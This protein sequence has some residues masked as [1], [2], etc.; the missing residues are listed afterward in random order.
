MNSASL[1]PS[2]TPPSAFI[3]GSQTNNYN[4]NDQGYQDQSNQNVTIEM[5]NKKEYADDGTEREVLTTRIKNVLFN[6][7]D[8]QSHQIISEKD[9]SSQQQIKRAVFFLRTLLV[10]TLIAASATSGKFMER[11]VGSSLGYIMME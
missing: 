6:K 4:I 8:I 3:T 10:F 7:K 9:R 1:H 11:S 5:T 2:K